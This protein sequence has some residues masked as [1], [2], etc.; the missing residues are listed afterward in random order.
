M[1]NSSLALQKLEND[2][3]DNIVRAYELSQGRYYALDYCGKH[4]MELCYLKDIK[5]YIKK[6]LKWYDGNIKKMCLHTPLQLN[7]VKWFIK[8]YKVS[9]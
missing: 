8:E 9:I 7:A 5:R 4:C 3:A 1:K 2:F 6:T